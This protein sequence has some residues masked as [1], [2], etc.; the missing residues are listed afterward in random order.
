MS[1][2]S[3]AP[4]ITVTATPVH[5][6]S[7]PKEQPLPVKCKIFDESWPPRR[8]VQPAA[9]RKISA[10]SSIASYVGFK[11]FPAVL[12][13]VTN[14]AGSGLGKEQVNRDEAVEKK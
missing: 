10:T 1:P 3:K 6:T 13:A 11:T 7:L 12:K 14:D 9:Y 8:P 5:F 4:S 2:G